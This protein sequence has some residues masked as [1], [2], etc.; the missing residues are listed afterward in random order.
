[1]SSSISQA[2]LFRSASEANTSVVS[3]RAVIW[4][5]MLKSS[6]DVGTGVSLCR[7][8][9]IYMAKMNVSVSGILS[10][11]IRTRLIT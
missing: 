10:A 2:F 6:T 4:P 11:N 5:Y 3:A 8:N 7:V 1:V 9:Q